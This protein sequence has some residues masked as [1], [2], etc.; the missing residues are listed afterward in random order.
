MPLLGICV[1]AWLHFRSLPLL[2]ASR[3]AALSAGTCLWLRAAN[4]GVVPA[5]HAAP[6]GSWMPWL[7]LCLAGPSQ[8]VSSV[9]G[10]T[11]GRSPSGCCCGSQEGLKVLMSQGWTFFFSCDLLFL[12]VFEFPSL[13]STN[14]LQ[15]PFY[16]GKP[17]EGHEWGWWFQALG[18][19]CI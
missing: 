6:W 12:L 15:L 3:R 13:C 9:F 2:P 14:A 11:G 7:L 5:L 18:I 17:G 1:P 8:L 19:P 4:Q 16:S 10:G